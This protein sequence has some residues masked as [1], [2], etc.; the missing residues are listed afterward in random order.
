MHPT[1]IVGGLVVVLIIVVILFAG[2][3]KLIAKA[4]AFF[5]SCWGGQLVDPEE[6]GSGKKYDPVDWQQILSNVPQAFAKEEDKSKICI[7]PTSDKA[8][9]QLAQEAK[10]G[11]K[12]KENG[13]QILVTIDDSI[14]PLKEGRTVNLDAH[15]PYTLHIQIQGID[16]KS[17]AACTIHIIDPESAG[18]DSYSFVE[19]G[20]AS[21]VIEGDKT[22]W[23]KP[24]RLKPVQDPQD[25]FASCTQ[26]QKFD[27]PFIIDE[28]YAQ[29]P[30][31]FQIIMHSNTLVWPVDP[32]GSPT[33]KLA[34]DQLIELASKRVGDTPQAQLTVPFRVNSALEITGLP[35]AWSQ[36]AQITL[37]CKNIVCEDLTLGEVWPS[38]QGLS[39]DQKQQLLT[40]WS[41]QADCEKLMNTPEAFNNPNAAHP[42]PVRI[43]RNLPPNN[44]DDT[45]TGTDSIAVPLKPEKLK[46]GKWGK[47]FTLDAK[48]LIDL[49]GGTSS[50]SNYAFR[51]KKNYLCFK[52]DFNTQTDSKTGKTISESIIK[53][54]EKPLLLDIFSPYFK[55]GNPTYP[56][57]QINMNYKTING[58]AFLSN[59]TYDKKTIASEVNLIIPPQACD[60][61]SMSGC[62]KLYYYYEPL[63]AFTPTDDLIGK[64]VNAL[65]STL[66]TKSLDDSNCEPF[67]SKKYVL[68]PNYK[69]GE[70][71]LLPINRQG[72]GYICLYPEDAS[73]SPD[74][75]GNRG[76]PILIKYLNPYQMI[77]ENLPRT[78]LA[79]AAPKP[80]R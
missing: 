45:Y 24:L 62:A 47:S 57:D 6:F 18:K 34:D 8:K 39:E 50:P 1:S 29:K 42:T 69:P 56:N 48:S 67:T 25:T 70:T 43:I 38:T 12:T 20:D 73:K 10:S 66:Y 78:P 68:V 61:G 54:A 40:P 17:T 15:R 55:Q 33:L 28:K 76:S 7:I 11:E 2:P 64:A 3:T 32:Q 4:S 27:F 51:D 71:T 65:F 74:G 37:T 79:P 72:M 21:Y 19:D 41:S 9:E 58:E 46:S 31:Q 36:Q 30:L 75:I 44:R 35:D 49:G 26:F 52:V 14:T 77:S 80:P 63:P 59:A 13:I 16:D 23:K 60:D 22:I 53:A 5:G